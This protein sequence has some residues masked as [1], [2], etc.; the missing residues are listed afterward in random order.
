MKSIPN[1]IS[2]H[3]AN[4]WILSPFLSILFNFLKPKS[5]LEFPNFLFKMYFESE[6]VTIEKVVPYF[7]IFKYIFYLKFLEQGK[8][9]F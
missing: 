3:Y 5:H 6:E 7:K 8:S 2:Y 4:S 9:I 1:W